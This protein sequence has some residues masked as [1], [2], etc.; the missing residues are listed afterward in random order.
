MAVCYNKI[1][2]QPD[3]GGKERFMNT[4]NEKIIE[5]VKR[6]GIDLIGFAPKSRFDCLPARRNPFTI[7][8]EGKTVVL[9]GKRV[10]RGS[11]RG[12]EEGTNFQ[13]YGMFGK[14]W[15]EDEFLALACYNMTNV[16]EDEGWEAVPVFP[17]PPEAAPMG[18]PVAEGKEAPN[19]HPD[20][21]FAAVACGLCEFGMSGIPLS[22]K[23]GSRQRFHMIIT[24]AEL[25]PTP[26]LERT[27]CDA[28][29]L[30]AKACPLGA[31]ST[32]ET[33]E[34]EICGKKMT[35]AKIDYDKCKVCKNG[36]CPSR[37]SP[38]ARPDRIAAL[39]N[40]TCVNVLETENKFENPFR[41]NDAWA[42]DSFGKFAERDTESANVLGGAFSKDGAR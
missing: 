24:D 11:L 9:V 23:Y 37:F 4:L 40:R 15:L 1:T 42:L 7:F 31:I 5:A 39:C 12:I 17:N 41:V 38:A 14:N 34:I 10:C 25:E 6:E 18:V 32:T 27:I 29:G 13:D 21:E 28:C 35:V 3:I 2:K 36:A 26:V 19:V 33:E 8:P 16:L 30:C 22:E 20:F